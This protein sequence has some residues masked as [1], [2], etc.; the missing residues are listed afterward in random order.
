LEQSDQEDLRLS[1]YLLVAL[2]LLFAL[3][4]LAGWRRGLVLM[5]ILAALQDPLRKLVPGTPGWLV[6]ATVPVFAAALVSCML[7]TRR[8]WSDFRLGYPHIANSIL[9]LAALSVPAAWLS[10]TYSDGSWM[11]T[12]IGAF[13][14]SVIFLSVITGF[15]YPRRL[16]ELRTL[17][18]TYCIAHGLMLTGSIFEYIGWF[19]DSGL[20]GSE[21]LGFEWVRRH[22]GY[23]VD[24]IAG[25]YR[26]PDVMGWHAA[27]VSMLTIV[28][29]QASKG[30]RRLGWSLL[31]ILA[32]AALLM[33]GRRKM[34]YMV[35]VFL[36]GLGWIYWQA[37][38]SSRVIALLGLIILP[39]GAAWLVGDQIAEDTSNIR[40]YSQTSD[41]T[42]D[43]LEQHGFESLLGTYEQTGF[44]GAGLGVATPGV[45][46]LDIERPRAWQESG[47]SRVLV[48]LG[49]MGAFGMLL[50]MAT[51]VFSVWRVTINQLRTRAAS[52]P[53]AAGL[54]AFF[55]ANVGSLVV[56]G[57]ILADPFIAAFLGL[58]VGMNLS[59]P[60][61]QA[62]ERQSSQAPR[63]SE[64]QPIAGRRVFS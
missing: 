2:S 33:C 15:H 10:A 9:L 18:A 19:K 57:Q 64:P 63:P 45:H 46:H 48:E 58:L 49:V 62:A 47:T 39:V 37:G 40:Y 51:I 23:S 50:V 5:V 1:L 43:R 24:M 53:Y 12:L 14:Y 16:P 32:L 55:L 17:L 27:A 22:S 61:L 44:F 31:C 4:A 6:L 26:S 13:S 7:R 59:L 54:F 52:A 3:R 38:K 28:L 11:M 42:M 41:E 30:R 34:V 21:A 25:F 29:A 35:P 60:R 36:A 8:F 20:I 56:S